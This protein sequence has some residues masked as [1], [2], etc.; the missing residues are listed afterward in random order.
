MLKYLISFCLEVYYFLMAKIHFFKFEWRRKAWGC[1]VKTLERSRTIY[2]SWTLHMSVMI[3]K[4]GLSRLHI[5]LCICVY[6][7]ILHCTCQDITFTSEYVTTLRLG[8]TIYI[9]EQTQSLNKSYS[10]NFFLWTWFQYF[11]SVPVAPHTNELKKNQSNC[12]RKYE[13]WGLTNSLFS[14]TIT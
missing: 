11:S 1:S 5:N 13:N 4:F 8:C 2:S 9:F 12:I 6:I 14:Y 3:F 7:Y 10:T